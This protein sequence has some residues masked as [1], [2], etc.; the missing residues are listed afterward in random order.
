[1]SPRDR[2]KAV[3]PQLRTTALKARILKN[4]V[5]MNPFGHLENKLIFLNVKNKIHRIT[6][7]IIYIGV[8]YFFGNKFVP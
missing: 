5:V 6:K 4:F 7:E 2:G 3:C 1:M 8:I